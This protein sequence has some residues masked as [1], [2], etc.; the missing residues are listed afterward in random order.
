MRKKR[1]VSKK[2]QGYPEKGGG[3][4]E[5]RKGPVYPYGNIQLKESTNQFSSFIVELL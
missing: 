5:E 4:A 1:E 2:G 3:K